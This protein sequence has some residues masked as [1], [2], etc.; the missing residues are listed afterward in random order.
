MSAESIKIS[1]SQAKAQANAIA[2]IAE[3]MRALA[4]CEFSETIQQISTAWSG[5]SARAYIAKAEK[6][7]CKILTTAKTLAAVADE[8]RT[9]AKQIY[10]A[11]MRALEIAQQRFSGSS[12][13]GGGGVGGRAL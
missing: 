13:G 2:E 9:E 1:F 12:G 6:A 5:E 10:D 3:N 11:E 4:E 8:I 7:K